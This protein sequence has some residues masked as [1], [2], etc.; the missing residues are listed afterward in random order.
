MPSACGV[1]GRIVVQ[2]REGIRAVLVRDEHGIARVYPMCEPASYYYQ[3]MTRGLWMPV[4]IGER[5]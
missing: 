1:G 2:I 5:I 3:V 4:L